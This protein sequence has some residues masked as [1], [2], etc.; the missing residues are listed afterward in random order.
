MRFLVVS[1]IHGDM[2]YVNKLDTEFAEADGVLFGGDFARF[3]EPETALPAL[4]TLLDKHESLFAVVGNCD[5]PDFLEELEK[6]DVSVQGG[7]VF[8]D[9][10]VFAGSGGALKFTGVTPNE[11]TDEE[12]VSDLSLAM[13]SQAESVDGR[14]PNMIAI[15]HQPPKD[16]ACDIVSGGVHVGSPL[17]RDFIEKVQPLVVVTG[18]IHESFAV[19]RIDSTVVMN[20]GS[21]AE[22]RYG[23]LEVEKGE[24]GLWSVTKAELCEIPSD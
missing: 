2:A 24:D 17:L 11:R 9:G 18:H 1:D 21:L 3:K 8:R 16:T 22:G 20:P 14:W 13:H 15:V 19:D 23:V 7:L 4:K 6:A 10:L 5:E 12:L